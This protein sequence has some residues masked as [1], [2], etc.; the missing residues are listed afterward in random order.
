M[1]KQ[2]RLI[3]IILI[4]LGTGLCNGLFGAGG[5]MIA[6]PSMVHI[7]KLDEHDAHATAIAVILPLAAISAYIYFTNG[8]LDMDRSIPVAVGGIIGGII[9]AFLLHRIPSKWL[10]KIFALFMVGAAVRMIF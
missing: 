4:G 10:H 9:G 6:V 1:N 2:A 5:G 3:K 7:L 8:F